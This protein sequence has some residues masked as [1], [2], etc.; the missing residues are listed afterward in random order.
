MS[1]GVIVQFRLIEEKAHWQNKSK[2]SGSA[3][4][5]AHLTFVGNTKLRRG[6]LIQFNRFPLLF[7]PQNLFERQFIANID[8]STKNSNMLISWQLSKYWKFK[9][10]NVLF[11]LRVEVHFFLLLQDV[12]DPVKNYSKILLSL[13][14][15]IFIYMNMV[16]PHYNI[17]FIFSIIC[18][19][20]CLWTVTIQFC[21]ILAYYN[22]PQICPEVHGVTMTIK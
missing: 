15:K 9:S 11:N 20:H 2:Y 4:Q 10:F 19:C 16:F 17:R 21:L 18:L 22:F 1:L 8:I 7:V 14:F 6:Y 5:K 12:R 3:P 13:I